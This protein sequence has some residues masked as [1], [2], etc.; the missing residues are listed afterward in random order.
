MIYPFDFFCLMI[1]KKNGILD[2]KIVV[3]TET[4]ENIVYLK[5]KINFMIC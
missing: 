3:Q 2:L 4:N 5:L 1:F